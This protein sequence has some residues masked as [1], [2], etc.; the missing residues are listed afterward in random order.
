M[1]YAGA[2]FADSVMRAMNGETVVE[3]TFIPLAADPE[4]AKQ[5]RALAAADLEFFAVP[6]ELGPDG[7]K[8]I[9]QFPSVDNVSAFER[10][11]LAAAIDALE[12][13]ISTGVNFAKTA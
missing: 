4:G 2:R 13:N 8:A 7:V 6:V 10:K 1:A 5:I 12:T 9:V 11:T 3:P